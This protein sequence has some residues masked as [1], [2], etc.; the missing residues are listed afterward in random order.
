MMG[1]YKDQRKT[2]QRTRKRQNREDARWYICRPS[3]R[4]HLAGQETSFTVRTPV[5][6][7]DLHGWRW[8]RLVVVGS[9]PPP[10]EFAP[11]VRQNGTGGGKFLS[12]G[13]EPPS[14][15]SEHPRRAGTT[16]STKSTGMEIHQCTFVL[17]IAQIRCGGFPPPSFG[18]E[19]G[20]FA[21][22]LTMTGIGHEPLNGGRVSIGITGFDQISSLA[23]R[24]ENIRDTTSIGRYDGYATRHTF[25]NDETKRFTVTGHN[26]TIGGRKRT[27]QFIPGQLSNKDS[28]GA[29]EMFVKFV[30]LRS[31]ADYRQSS[32]GRQ[33]LQDIFE[34]LE[35]FFRTETSHIHQTKIVRMSIGHSMAHVFI[36]E[37]RMEAFDINPF[38]PYI[39]TR[40]A[41]CLQFRL[42]WCRCNECQIGFAVCPTQQFPTNFFHIRDETQIIFPIT[43]QMGVITHNEWNAQ[44]PSIENS[45]KQQESWR[46]HMNEIWL[47]PFHDACTFHF[48]QIDTERNVIVQ[49]K[50]KALGV[51][52]GIRQERF[53]QLW[54]RCLRIDSQNVNYI[55]G[56]VQMFEEFLEPI[57]IA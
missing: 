55:L 8:G 52:D 49:W 48:G 20:C 3:G 11:Q 39:D 6:S 54:W 35:S 10:P 26:E 5:S 56:L 9:H 18:F 24:I 33:P 34:I 40:D 46:C 7:R 16:Q 30:L 13:T 28:V 47:E 21:H 19:S 1:R 15:Q 32:V 31:F 53:G 27:G 50:G 22:P 45:G 43:G 36:A 38:A 25:Q 23:G 41:S 44:D 14:E 2:Q 37:F 42:H 57:R 51:S 29:F 4:T 17:D 12:K